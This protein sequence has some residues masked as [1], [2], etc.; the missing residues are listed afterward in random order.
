MTRRLPT[1]D[2]QVQIEL[3]RARAA[4][5]REVLAQRV[6]QVGRELE[7]TQL[8]RAFFPM[9]A[10]KGG[11]SLL[12]QALGLARRH[13]LASSVLPTLLM[14]RGRLG[15]L[16]RAAAMAMTGWQLFKAWQE[17]K[18]GSGEPDA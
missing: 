8:L 5:E 9:M 3:L 16:A 1:I 13:P 12:M 18:A 2:R 7:P 4:V 6:T 17:R 14:G 15:G 11:A 10:G